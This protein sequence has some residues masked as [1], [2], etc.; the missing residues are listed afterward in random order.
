MVL[1]SFLGAVVCFC[2]AIGWAKYFG[3]SQWDVRLILGMGVQGLIAFFCAAI[4]V[5]G[6]FTMLLLLVGGMAPLH[7]Y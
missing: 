1:I 5:W 3:A 6:L 7:P 4:G 2:S